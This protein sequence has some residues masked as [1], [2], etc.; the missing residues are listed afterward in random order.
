M[1]GALGMFPVTPGADTLAL[2]GPLFESIAVH[3]PNGK[4]LQ[5]N[6][7]NAGGDAPFIQSLKVNGTAT[8]HTYVTYRDIADGATLDFTMG[9][10]PNKS[11][12][13]GEE[14]APPSFNDGWTPPEAPDPFGTNLALGKAISGSAACNDDAENVWNLVDG[15]LAANSKFC[16]STVPAWFIV[17][18]GQAYDVSQF[19]MKHAGMGGENTGWNTSDYE[20]WT[21]TDL[22]NPNW[23]LQLQ[24]GD[25][26]D[27]KSVPKPLQ[28]NTKS[29]TND[30]LAS[31]VS[32]RY[33]KV[34]I[35]KPGAT[36][37]KATR[38]YEFEVYQ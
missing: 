24:V 29:M 23:V 33:V 18:L 15:Q 20:I 35:T 30:K 31:P 37:P 9:A 38:I 28:S 8:T 7:T 19:V 22:T 10:M 11:W 3:M 2:H 12:G 27:S 21:A 16:G 1:F 26:Y 4:T 36:E 5:I 34:N 32:A 13:I 25:S 17:D 6:G 14:D